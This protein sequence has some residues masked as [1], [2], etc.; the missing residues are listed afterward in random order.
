MFLLAELPLRRDAH[1]KVLAN[2][3]EGRPQIA[4]CQPFV[5]GAFG[6]DPAVQDRRMRGIDLAF[7]CLQ[8]VAFLYP[9]KTGFWLSTMKPVIFLRQEQSQSHDRRIVGKA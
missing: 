7:E 2:A 9:Q 6:I 5:D 3:F 1:A 4:R 8:P